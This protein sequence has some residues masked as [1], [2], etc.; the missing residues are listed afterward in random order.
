MSLLAPA[1]LPFRYK[2]PWARETLRVAGMLSMVA[3]EA[4]AVGYSGLTGQVRRMFSFARFV[5]RIM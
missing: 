1:P 5:A 3:V 4:S 2:G